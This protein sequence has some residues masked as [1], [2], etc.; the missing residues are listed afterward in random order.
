MI[1][2]S[3]DGHESVFGSFDC[4]AGNAGGV[5]AFDVA[6]DGGVLHPAAGK[7]ISGFSFEAGG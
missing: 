2:G 5:E 7:S 6:A 1:S 3:A 4:N